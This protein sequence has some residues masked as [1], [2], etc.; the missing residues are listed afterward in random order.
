MPANRTF[1]DHPIAGVG[2]VIVKDDQ[3]VLIK[4]GKAPRRGDWSLPGGGVELGETTR[5][6]ISREIREETGLEV[7]L[8]GIID[9]ID[10]IERT[11]AGAVSFHYVLID[12][13][14][15]YRAGTLIA[16][17]DADDARFVLFDEA[18]V[19][20][21]WEET[22]RIIRAAKDMVQQKQPD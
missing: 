17:S 21:L 19:L 9:C 8:A 16:G 14:A 20:P 10:Y 18:L 11:D 4:R 1:P 12:F 22:K 13:L 3:I 5:Q 6:A 7:E 2:A 15:Y